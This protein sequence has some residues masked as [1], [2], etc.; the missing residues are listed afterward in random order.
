MLG[1]NSPRS[2]KEP[3][4]DERVKAS[5][6]AQN[7]VGIAM[8]SI[9]D[10]PKRD[11]RHADPSALDTVDGIVRTGREVVMNEKGR[12][13]LSE[14]WAVVRRVVYI[15]TNMNDKVSQP[16]PQQGGLQGLLIRMRSNTGPGDRKDRS[17]RQLQLKNM[18][19]VNGGGCEQKTR[20]SD[21]LTHGIRQR[22][23][24]QLRPPAHLRERE[25]IPNSGEDEMR[26][27]E[28]DEAIMCVRLF[29]RIS[30]HRGREI[31]GDAKNADGQGSH[32]EEETAVKIRETTDGSGV[33]DA[34]TSNAG[35]SVHRPMAAPMHRR[36][37]DK[38]SPERVSM[39]DRCQAGRGER[40]KRVGDEV[41]NAK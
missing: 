16:D 21:W 10:I 2:P 12:E 4:K 22:R 38:H 35:T 36:N 33:Y 13:R 34:E 31:D 26:S 41:S 9:R 15:G 14:V 23:P 20:S 39:I 24:L 29:V 7:R 6:F 5:Q 11:C 8:W 1:T 27:L 19:P 37:I 30:S 17:V 40:E 18:I 32:G 25:L 28:E 3:K